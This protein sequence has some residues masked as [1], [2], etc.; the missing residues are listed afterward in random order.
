MAD[1]E[2][3]KPA[4]KPAPKAAG[5]T[6]VK[7]DTKAENKTSAAQK[8]RAAASEGSATAKKPAQKKSADAK[9]AEKKPDDGKPA[10]AGGSTAKA[11]RDSLEEAG[12]AL[13]QAG[14][15]VKGA[16]DQVKKALSGIGDEMSAVGKDIAQ[17]AKA[18]ADLASDVYTS[19]ADAVS[20]AAENIAHVSDTKRGKKPAEKEARL[21]H[22]NY[23]LFALTPLFGV[24]CIA[25]LVMA[26][27][28]RHE[29]GVRG[30]VLESHYEWLIWTFWYGL[31]AGAVSA[32]LALIYIGYALLAITV[33]I[34]VWRL[35]KGWLTLY[36]GKAMRNPMAVL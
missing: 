13:N 2:A 22:I 14:D 28:R 21:G 1:E 8:P 24:T 3:K 23:F 26:Y 11:A 32:L 18:A 15:A 29:T 12:A 31:I 5:K 27:L 4:A 19:A 9:A 34:L 17:D 30:T 36:D 25:G 20:S 33:L 10:G 7:A 35:V 6:A 16:S